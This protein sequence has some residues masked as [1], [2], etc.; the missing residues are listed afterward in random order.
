M[1]SAVRFEDRVRH[2]GL[3]GEHAAIAR[4][5]LDFLRFCV[6]VE[7]FFSGGVQ[8]R[9]TTGRRHGGPEGGSGR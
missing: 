2:A 3:R 9:G 5:H 6:A 8:P 7:G 1:R 4:S